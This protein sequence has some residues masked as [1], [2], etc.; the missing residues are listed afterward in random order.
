MRSTHFVPLL[1]YFGVTRDERHP[2]L[3]ARLLEMRLDEF[4]ASSE[5][6]AQLHQEAIRLTTLR[7][8]VHRQIRSKVPGRVAACQSCT[9]Q[10]TMG[11]L[12]P[13]GSMRSFW[14]GG[15]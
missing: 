10:R 3:P 13:R 6:A 4:F 12:T 11:A 7:I 15:D 1:E 5:F 2:H 8:G 14:R 9:T